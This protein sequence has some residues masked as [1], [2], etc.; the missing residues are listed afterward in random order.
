MNYFIFFLGLV[1]VVL[2]FITFWRAR[3]SNLTTEQVVQQTLQGAYFI[4]VA[5]CLWGFSFSP[6]QRS[7]S[8]LDLSTPALLWVAFFITVPEILLIS[9]LLQRLAYKEVGKATLMSL[10]LIGPCNVGIVQLVNG[11]LDFTPPS[12][13]IVRVAGKRSQLGQGAHNPSYYVYVT[14]WNYPGELVKINIRP[15]RYRSANRGTQLEVEVGSGFLGAEWV[16]AVRF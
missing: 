5:L 4:F 3:A 8:L 7:A 9:H 13:H 2:L 16:R 15:S 10:L 14:D 11:A 12:K 1:G 6:L